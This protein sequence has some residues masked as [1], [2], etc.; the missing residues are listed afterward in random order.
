MGNGSR[1]VKLINKF[2]EIHENNSKHYRDYR[3]SAY[4]KSNNLHQLL[5]FNYDEKYETIFREA[6]RKILRSI[7]KY[8]EER[9]NEE[10]FSFV[11]YY[12][13]ESGDIISLTLAGYSRILK[14]SDNIAE[15]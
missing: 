15:Y 7:Q 8:S 2:L 9:L 13:E 12:R 10:K 14:K 11:Y 1:E 3:L 6:K 5:L 4:L